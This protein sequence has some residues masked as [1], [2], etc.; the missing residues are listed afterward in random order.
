VILV[1]YGVAE[2][3]EPGC[4]RRLLPDCGDQS[5]KLVHVDASEHEEVER[6]ILPLQMD[7]KR[8]TLSTPVYA[9]AVKA[10]FQSIATI[11]KL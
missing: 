9:K 10:G 3:D 4:I 7:P 2:R 6:V 1:A 8:Q 11:A 5:R